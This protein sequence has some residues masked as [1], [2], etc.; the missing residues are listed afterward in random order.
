M[1]GEGS[2]LGKLSRSDPECEEDLPSVGY[3][4]HPGNPQ[5]DRRR[6]KRFGA[7]DT[8]VGGESMCS[9]VG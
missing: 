4:P 2:D 8:E 1:I 6:P 9:D 3:S 5:H 7:T